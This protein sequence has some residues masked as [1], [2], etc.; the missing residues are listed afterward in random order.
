MTFT[1]ERS[2][3]DDT[4]NIERKSDSLVKS[5]AA[6]LSLEIDMPDRTILCQMYI[7]PDAKVSRVGNRASS[8]FKALTS[9]VYDLG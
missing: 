6:S 7:H 3:Q 2:K 1:H 9:P 4:K 5:G 8:H